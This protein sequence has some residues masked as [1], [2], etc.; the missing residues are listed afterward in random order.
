MVDAA[1]RPAASTKS[2]RLEAGET[3]VVAVNSTEIATADGFQPGQALVK[4]EG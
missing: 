2:T 1:G 3:K 4:R